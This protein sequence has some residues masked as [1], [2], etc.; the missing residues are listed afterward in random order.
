MSRPIISLMGAAGCG[1]STVARHLVEQMGMLE[2]SFAAPLKLLCADLFH[3]DPSRMNDLDYK[4][5]IPMLEGGVPQCPGP[6]GSGMSR[7]E[8]LQ[9]V[10]TEGFRH[11]D[12][13]FWVK[14]AES[15]MVQVLR[16]G[17]VLGVVFS[18]LRFPNE[19]AMTRRHGGSVVLVRR[20]GGPVGT[21]ADSHQSEKLFHEIRAD[22]VLEAKYGDLDGL[23]ASAERL[24]DRV[25]GRA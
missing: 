14:Q 10:G 7:R 12:P 8:V 5:E 21:N 16:E 4:E 13:D 15:A 2:A 6:H 1:K 18:D 22:H 24:L 20:L 25:M 23:R 3:W 9:H 19:A 11:V 17:R